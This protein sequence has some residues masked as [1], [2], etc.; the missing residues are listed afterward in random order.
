MPTNAPP[1]NAVGTNCEALG[2]VFNLFFEYQLLENLLGVEGL[3]RLHVGI[4]LLDLAE[5]LAHVLHANR[6]ISDLGDGVRGDLAADRRLWNEVEQH[7]ASQDQDDDPEKDAIPKFAFIFCASH[8]M[9]LPR[10]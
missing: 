8:P 6:L 10:Q 2:L 4:S 1:L 7:A 5:L 3:E 9:N